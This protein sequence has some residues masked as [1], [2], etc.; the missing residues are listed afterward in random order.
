[1]AW[2]DVRYNCVGN[3]CSSTC[4]SIS[5]KGGSNSKILPKCFDWRCCD[6]YCCL[7]DFKERSF[8]SSFN[9]GK[10]CSNCMGK[11]SEVC[12]WLSC[13]FTV[14]LLCYSNRYNQASCRHT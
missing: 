11:V 2:R 4:R 5:C 9:R 12:A 13:C 1:M 6:F 8:C 10:G 14:V 3:C 7:V